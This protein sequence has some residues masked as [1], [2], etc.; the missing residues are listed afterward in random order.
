ME[1]YLH[2]IGLANATLISMHMTC[3]LCNICPGSPNHLFFECS[4]SNKIWKEVKKL[5]NQETVP[6]KWDDVV[7]C[8]TCQKFNRSIKS[9]LRRIILAGYMYYIWN[10]RNKRQFSNEKRDNKELLAAVI[11]YTRLKLS[12]LQIKKTTQVL[13]IERKWRVVINVKKRRTCFSGRV[14]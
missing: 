12:S 11:N 13:E 9:V 4:Y 8:M 1:D 14:R 5:T 7:S 3:S 10:E 2:K 6:N